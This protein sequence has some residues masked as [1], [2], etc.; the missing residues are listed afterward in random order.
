MQAFYRSILGHGDAQASPEE[1]QALRHALIDYGALQPSPVQNP[2]DSSKGYDT[3]YAATSGSP[4]FTNGSVRHLL[5]STPCVTNSSQQK[6]FANVQNQSFVPPPTPAL[7]SNSYQQAYSWTSPP[8]IPPLEA[9][10]TFNTDSFDLSNAELE[11]LMMN[12]TQDFWASFPGEV[13][14][15]YQ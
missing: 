7:S 12:A 2:T 13:G 11:E 1:R 15:G 10:D 8:S 9:D 5:E 14:A 3:P 4:T 6:P